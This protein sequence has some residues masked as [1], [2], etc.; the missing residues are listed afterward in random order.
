MVKEKLMSKHHKWFGIK[1]VILG[2]IVLINAY[3]PFVRWDVLIGILLVLM[4]I[5]KMTMPCRK[6]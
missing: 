1:M 2:A 6:R 4:G 5:F 3:S